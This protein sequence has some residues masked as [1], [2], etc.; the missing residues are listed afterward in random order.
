MKRYLIAALLT[1]VG[2]VAVNAASLAEQA[3]SAYAKQDYPAALSLYKN[4]I[5]KEGTSSNLYYNLGNAYYRTGDVGHAIISYERAL[6]LDPSNEDARINLNF[7]NG[8]I[9]GAPEDD[10]S[11]L[12]NLHETVTSWFSPDA[13]AWVAFGF[14]L[15][16]CAAIA[17]YLFTSNVTLRKAGFFG[18]LVL[19]VIFI[20]VFV[21]AMTTAGALDDHSRAIVT[22]PVTNLRSQPTTAGSKTDKVVPI[23]QGA[24][25]EILDSISTPDDPMVS[26]W[27]EVKINNST[28]AWLNSADVERI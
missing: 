24:K 22:S 13:W 3:D 16:V 14:F 5:E 2:V 10:S 28:R 19:L 8:R 1:L 27:Y 20:Y 23:P 6:Q 12:A 25:V 4:A 18:A 21:I 7:V 15:L 11:F 26:M 9:A 17:V